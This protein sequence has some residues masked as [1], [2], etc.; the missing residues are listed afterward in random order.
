M[1]A[2]SFSRA[3][4]LLD[5]DDRALENKKERELMELQRLR[6]SAHNL[7]QIG[8][9]N[10]SAA[11]LRKSIQ[12]GKRADAI[13]ESLPVTHVE[14]KRDIRLASQATHA[15][16]LVGI[17]DLTISRPDGVPLFRIGKL[18]IGP[19]ERVAVLGRN[20]S[21]KT[22][23][24]RKLRAGFGQPDDA[25]E[26]GLVIAPSL[27]MGYLDQ[28]M[29][30]LPDNENLRDYLNGTYGTG[31]QRTIALLA[32]AGFPLAQHTTIISQLSP[33]ERARLALLALR[34]RAPNFYLM[35]EPTNHLDISGQEQ[36]E[37]EILAHEAAAVL[38]SHDRAFVEHVGTRFL[39][40][41]NTQILEIEE[42]D[43]FYKSLIDNVALLTLSSRA[44]IL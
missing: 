31:L 4:Q 9:D 11:A 20:G 18:D 29:S 39:V 19:A 26:Q 1:Y 2:Y 35:D 13:Q 23:L 21:G 14:Q 38:V 22:Q 30:Q 3:R 44:K 40:V 24:V 6:K 10:Y 33:G 42:P 12:I 5:D 25:R 27:I 41:E 43:L 7:R 36:L 37:T 8:V 32:S 17:K 15:K 28:N 34:L 16:R